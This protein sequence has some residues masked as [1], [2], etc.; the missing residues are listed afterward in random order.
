M[1]SFHLCGHQVYIPAVQTDRQA[2]HSHNTINISKYIYIKQKGICSKSSRNVYWI[3]VLV[4]QAR[5]SPEFKAKNAQNGGQR[6][7]PGSVSHLP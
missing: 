4:T 7:R 3:K 5:R 1:P 6:G 2:K